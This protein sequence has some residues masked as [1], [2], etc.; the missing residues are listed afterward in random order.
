MSAAPA[1][2]HS[3]GEEEEEYRRPS[4]RLKTA[5][6]QAEDREEGEDEL[7]EGEDSDSGSLPGEG[8]P[9]VDHRARWTCSQ[10]RGGRKVRGAGRGGVPS[11]AAAPPSSIH[12]F[13]HSGLRIRLTS[14]LSGLRA[15]ASVRVCCVQV[16]QL[17]PTEGCGCFHLLSS[18][19][20][21]ELGVMT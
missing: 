1:A 16:L 17:P 2:P 21:K 11:G 8:E 7:E 18:S 19:L 6:R 13:L 3:D 4:K 20:Q 14:K 15:R 9:A 12:A 10:Y 5:V